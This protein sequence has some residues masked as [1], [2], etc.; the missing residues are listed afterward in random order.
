LSGRA[1]GR[2]AWAKAANTAASTRSVLAG[3]RRRQA[4]LQPAGG[5][6]DDQGRFNLAQL[7]RQLID[8][9]LV[10]GHVPSSPRRGQMDIQTAFGHINPDKLFRTHFVPLRRHFVHDAHPCKMR[11]QMPQQPFGLIKKNRR[12]A[13]RSSTGW[14]SQRGIELSRRN[15]N[16]LWICGPFA[17]GEPGVLPWKTRRVSHRKT[18]FAHKLHRQSLFMETLNKYI[19][20]HT[21]LMS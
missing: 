6:H 19:A 14:V 7:R 10:T 21:I 16:R 3:Q 20:W 18:P 5:F 1:C 15:Q 4:H 9:G 12:N 8:F 13:P 2:I 17:C 11:A